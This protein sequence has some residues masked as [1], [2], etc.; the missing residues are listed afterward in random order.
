LKERGK[1]LRRGAKPL[2]NSLINNLFVKRLDK[3][4]L[5]DYTDI[6]E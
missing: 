4:I 2:L 3:P 5:L 1:I 6:S